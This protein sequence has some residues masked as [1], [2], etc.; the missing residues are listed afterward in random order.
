MS[1]I[2]IHY[3]GE[4]VAANLPPYFH[5]L[6]LLAGASV[7]HLQV[8]EGVGPNIAQS[9]VDWFAR[10]S[11]QLI[12]EKLHLAGVWP[13]ETAFIE[14]TISTRPLADLTFVVTGTLTRFTRHE[15]KDYIQSRGGKVT[16]SISKKTHYLVAGEKAGSKLNKAQNLGV[17]IINEDQLRLLADKN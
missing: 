15:I 11:N 5:D 17:A 13:T 7:E 2:F 14:G 3:S 6:S 16:G 9:I 10:P 4:V 8:I 12:I 1:L